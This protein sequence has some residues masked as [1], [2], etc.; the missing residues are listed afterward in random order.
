MA[1]G[2]DFD[3]E[4]HK[5]P[6]TTELIH[7]P[8]YQCGREGD[9]EA[10]AAGLCPSPSVRLRQ[11]RSCLTMC[12]GSPL[13]GLAPFLFVCHFLPGRIAR[14]Q[15]RIRVSYILPALVVGMQSNHPSA[16]PAR[17]GALHKI[18]SAIYG[19]NLSPLGQSASAAFA[20]MRN[21]GRLPPPLISSRCCRTRRE[22]MNPGRRSD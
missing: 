14:R 3:A 6:T 12:V 7:A 20:A 16:A 15:D 9:V 8:R 18:H 5:R 19:A 13:T 2:H 17:D 11:R 22:A 4:F 21:E 1:I 10:V